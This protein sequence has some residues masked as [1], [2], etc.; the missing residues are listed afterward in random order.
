MEVD[1]HAPEKI[2]WSQGAEYRIGDLPA[3]G[4]SGDYYHRPAFIHGEWLEFDG[5]VMFVDPSGK[6]MDETAYA[7][8][9]Q[10][11]GNLF[12][13]E[14][15]SFREGYTEP[16]LEGLAQAA[17]RQEVN[18]IILED[19]FG[20]G[21]LQS[22]LQPYLRRIY[23]C[24][25]EPARSNVQKE[26]RIINALEPVMNQ[27]RLIVNRSVIENDSKAKDE[28]SVETHLAY[29]LFHQLTHLTVD[30]N[31][32]QHDDRLDALAGAVEYWND[33]LAIDEEIAM[34]ERDMELLDLEIAAYNGEIVGALDAT[35]LGIPLDELPQSETEEGWI[36]LQ[37]FEN[38]S[39][40]N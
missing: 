30:R 6:G 34:R 25:V 26:R 14:V 16:V 31:S 39:L 35:I 27:H 21:M 33:S 5:C 8:V 9:A 37:G 7:I 24:T 40:G 4:F 18:L 32:L 20:Q 36:E 3:V 10:L 17:K 23:P 13:L 1:D 2:V 19:Q 22:L 15:G 29:Q 12:V 28:D 11:N 38:Q